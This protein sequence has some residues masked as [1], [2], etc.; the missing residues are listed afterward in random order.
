MENLTLE[1]D[2]TGI[3]TASGG[4]GYLKAGL[5]TAVV[6]DITK[7][8]DSNRL[9]VYMVTSGI[10]HRDSFNLDSAGALPFLKAFLV[11]A[12]LPESKLEGKSK[13][14]FHKMSGRTVYFN[15]VPPEMDSQGK[16]VQGS[17]PKY[18]FYTKERYTQMQEITKL[19]PQDVQVETSNGAGAPVAQAAAAKSDDEYDFILDD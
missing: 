5:H 14:P 13:I 12:G 16:A 9:Y 11:S 8:D 4:L 1:L 10:R 7:Y 19:A 17:Y 6:A 18:T 15:Y 3:I 2:F